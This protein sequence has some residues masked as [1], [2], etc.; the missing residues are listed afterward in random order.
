MSYNT[1]HTSPH[2]WKASALKSLFCLR[3]ILRFSKKENEQK[4]HIK[5][6]SFQIKGGKF[7]ALN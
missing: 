4:S 5:P 1:P 3:K 6:T 2:V 7:E